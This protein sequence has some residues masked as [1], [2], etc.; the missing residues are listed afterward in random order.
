MSIEI[1]VGSN[2]PIL[3]Q[4]AQKHIKHTDADTEKHDDSHAFVAGKTQM[5]FAIFLVEIAIVAEWCLLYFLNMLTSRLT[6][7]ATKQSL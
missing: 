2:N 5:A 3:N 4:T 1:A 6:V 7:H